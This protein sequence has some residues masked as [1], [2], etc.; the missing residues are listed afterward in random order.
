MLKRF[1]GCQGMTG[2]DKLNQEG[3]L[4]VRKVGGRA[5]I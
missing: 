4:C 2:A 3:G 5:R 1:V